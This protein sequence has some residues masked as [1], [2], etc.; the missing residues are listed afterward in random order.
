MIILIGPSASGKTEIAKLLIKNFNYKKFITT[1]SRKIRV[2]EIN[3]VDYHFVSKEEFIEKIKNNEFIEYVLYNDN[4]YGTYKNEIDLDK[5]LIVEPSGLKV[6]KSLNDPTIISFYIHTP[7]KIREERM[8]NRKDDLNDVKKRL[9]ND[10]KVFTNDIFDF[11]DA[12]IENND[13]SLTDLA[14]KIDTLYKEIIHQ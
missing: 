10:D 8:I 1:T 9:Y 13:V 11:V 7:K 2:N 4:F 5:V 12:T 6:F 14:A 3:D